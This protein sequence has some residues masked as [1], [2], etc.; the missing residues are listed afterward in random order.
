MKFTP[1]KCL[2]VIRHI[3]TNL[4]KIGVASNW[5]NRAKALKI[6]YD[7]QPIVVV[8][9][10]KNA[11][12]EKEL[13]R[14]YDAYRLP[15]SE[16]FNLNPELLTNLVSTALNYGKLLIS[17]YKQ[18]VEKFDVIKILSKQ[19]YVEISKYF[20]YELH[21]QL[22]LQYVQRMICILEH[23]HFYVSK[24]DC[25]YFKQLV[26]LNTKKLKIQDNEPLWVDRAYKYKI[27]EQY[28]D[29]FFTVFRVYASSYMT[30]SNFNLES[31]VFTTVKFNKIYPYKRLPRS[32]RVILKFLW[33]DQTIFSKLYD[34]Q[35][36]LKQRPEQYFKYYM[37]SIGPFYY[38]VS[39]PLP[40]PDFGVKV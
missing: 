3:T 22:R 24:K 21:R 12:A 16:Y 1:Y 35:T 28:I 20:K 14:V 33:A 29:R 25:V 39:D 38:T 30:V 10:E 36:N 17:P 27:V 9:T 15:G 7:T 8:L 18:Q 11:E 2:Y 4:I 26:N 31:L 13:H 40:A 23:L 6:G 32:I 37:E 34:V 5:Y 19:D